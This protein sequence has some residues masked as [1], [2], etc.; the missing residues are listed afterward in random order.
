M[1]NYFTFVS[2]W[3]EITDVCYEE[4]LYAVLAIIYIDTR[5]IFIGA[6]KACK[7]TST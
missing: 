4:E 1:Q 7:M 3:I 5:K 6:K 2:I